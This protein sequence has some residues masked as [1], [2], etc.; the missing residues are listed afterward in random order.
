[1]VDAAVSLR[2]DTHT[3]GRTY[4]KICHHVKTIMDIEVSKSSFLGV[5]E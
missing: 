5:F 2:E 4:D 1:M 3:K